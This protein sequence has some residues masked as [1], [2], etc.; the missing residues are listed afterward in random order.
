MILLVLNVSINAFIAS[1]TAWFANSQ[2]ITKRTAD[3]IS[4]VEMVLFLLEYLQKIT[5][6]DHDA[7]EYIID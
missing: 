5:G 3:W 1:E 2:G 6:F 7:F 4:R